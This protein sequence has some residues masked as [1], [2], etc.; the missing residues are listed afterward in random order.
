MDILDKFF[1]KFSYKFP[2]GYPDINDAQDMLMLEG[3]LKE[4]GIDLNEAFTIFPTSEEEIKNPKIKEIFKIIKQY[5]NLK[6]KDP[7]VLDPNKPQTVKVT[8]SL[9]RDSQFVE[10]FSNQLGIKLDP[11]STTGGKYKG[12]TIKW[13]EGSRG[14][15]GIESKGLKFEG[16]LETDL[17]LYNI[18]G[19]TEENKSKFKYPDIII[20][21]SKEIGIK[22]GNFTVKLEGD[23][24]QSRPLKFEGGNPIV[25]FSAGTAAATLTDLTITK[26]N[27]PYYISAKFG[28][29]LTFFNS[30]VTKIFPSDQIKAGEITNSLGKILLE[31]FGIDNK[32]FCRV[33]NE[34]GE[35][36]FSKESGP[37][38]KYSQS[39]IKGLIKSGIGEGYYMAHGG[40]KGDQFYEIDSS[41]SDVA[42]DTSS[43]DVYYG[44]LGGDGKR[45]DIV[46]ESPTYR[47]KVNIRN[48]AGGLYPTHIMC[49]YKKK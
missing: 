35:T 44:G 27:T 8:R 41:Y 21:M 16:E 14:G 36:N 30:G 32:T 9:Q 26:E 29:T 4:I 49:D 37:S 31:T 10:F 42:S 7:I 1:K 18:E 2:K 46:F 3:I 17:N 19:L 5:P 48:K 11:T 22:P 6:L 34:Y 47:F 38:P 33:F 25:G 28:N 40:T 20:E 12:V 45:I 43:P 15:R 24:N 13:G 23:K 39:K